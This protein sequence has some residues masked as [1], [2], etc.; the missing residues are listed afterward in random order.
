MFSA[1]WAH[2]TLVSICVLVVV[3]VVEVIAYAGWE[4]W[5]G[6]PI[7]DWTRS[8]LE[9][10]SSR[11]PNAELLDRIARVLGAAGT[12]LTAAYGVYKGI[13]Y[14]DYNLPERLK[15]LLQRAD[16]RLL[17]DREPLLAAVSEPV[18]EHERGRRY[19]TSIP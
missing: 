10:L 8:L 1:R 5:L 6:R 16:E 4:G 17:R 3:E 19:S 13:Y 2:R 18:S 9:P 15:Q 7:Q 12:A 11:L 14:A